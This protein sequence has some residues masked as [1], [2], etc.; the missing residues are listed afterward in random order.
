MNNTA[1]KC[2]NCGGNLL[3]DSDSG[4]LKCEQCDSLFQADFMDQGG[5]DPIFQNE[6]EVQMSTVSGQEMEVHV[7]KCD[8]CGGELAVTE[9]TAATRCP[10]CGSPN[11]IFDRVTND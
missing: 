2:P 7:F 6:E 8:S 3:F 1:Y 5:S 9:K 4:Q 10:Y 11:I